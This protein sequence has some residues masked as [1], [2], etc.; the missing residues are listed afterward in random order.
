MSYETAPATEMLASH[1][2]CCAR[3]LVDAVSVEAGVGPECRKKH[4]F[5]VAQ[6][7][8]DWALAFEAFAVFGTAQHDVTA[9]FAP[10]AWGVDA[11]KVCNVLVHRIALDQDSTLALA[12]VEAVH[13]LGF[14]KLAKRCAKRLASITIEAEGD[15]LVVRAPYSDDSVAILRRVPGRR[16]EKFAPDGRKDARNRFPA[17]SKRELFAALTRAF[18]GAT[19][20]GPKGLFTLARLEVA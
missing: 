7:E 12:C 10:A 5:G 4:G 6:G 13:A 8:P 15:E 14:V 20:R 3:P 9:G 19:V 1:C 2:A 11:H 18:P 16:F 17:A